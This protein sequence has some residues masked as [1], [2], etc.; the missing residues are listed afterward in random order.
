[1]ANWWITLSQNERA[2]LERMG[3]FTKTIGPGFY[4]L[5]PGLHRI[6]GPILIAQQTVRLFGE[7]G[8]EIRAELL[9][10]HVTAKNVDVFVR[11]HSPDISY[12]TPDGVNR[13][14]VYRA[15]YEHEDWREA[16]ATLIGNA[17][18]EWLQGFSNV[19]EA[20]DAKGLNVFQK[21]S[22]GISDAEVDYIAERALSLGFDILIV[23]VQDIDPSQEWLNQR[24]MVHQRES[25]EMAARFV[26]GTRAQET[27]GFFLN[28]LARSQGKTPQQ[29]E[30]ELKSNVDLQ[31]QLMVLGQEILLRRMSLDRNALRDIRMTGGGDLGSTLAGLIALFRSYGNDEGQGE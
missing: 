27:M 8:S 10:G 4:I 28:M 23:T 29:L 14:G 12:P 15:F 20:L 18:R 2:A 13:N 7:Q 25:E 11:V 24:D 19:E 16:L 9:N 26:A 21:G 3:S 22:A 5:I 31:N 6:R 17:V 30:D 1:M